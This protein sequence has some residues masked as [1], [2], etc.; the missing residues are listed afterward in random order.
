MNSTQTDQLSMDTCDSCQHL[1]L[2]LMMPAKRV[3][4]VTSIT[5]ECPFNLMTQWWNI[6]DGRTE[7]LCRMSPFWV[8]HNCVSVKINN[9]EGLN[10]K[11]FLPSVLWRCWLGVRKGIRPVKNCAVGCCMV[12]CLRWGAYLHIAQQ[13]PLALIMS[14]CSK[15]WLV[16]P[17]W[18]LPLWYWL[19]RVVPDKIQKSHKTI[20]CVWLVM[21][22]C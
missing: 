18:F 11:A 8:R 6:S 16:L 4:V 15:S 17:S 22:S 5:E 21:T 20:V 19:T 1:A 7:C 12:I 13:M 3:T 9:W 10:I 14:C 2:V